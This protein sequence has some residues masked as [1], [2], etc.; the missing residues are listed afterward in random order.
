MK[1][2]FIHSFLRTVR[3]KCSFHLSFK[4]LSKKKSVTSEGI[5]LV[6]NVNKWSYSAY[7]IYNFIHR[8]KISKNIQLRNVPSASGVSFGCRWAFHKSFDKQIFL[9]VCKRIWFNS[10]CSHISTLAINLFL[11]VKFCVRNV[12]LDYCPK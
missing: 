3:N 12:A 7:E 4:L 5:E 10:V 9:T 6:Y 2:N 8:F 11:R 1:L